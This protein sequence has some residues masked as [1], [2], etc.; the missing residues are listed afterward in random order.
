MSPSKLS[1]FQPN[2]D[3][4]LSDTDALDAQQR[5]L[6]MQ[7]VTYSLERT[8]TF[9][10][11]WAASGYL[12]LTVTEDVSPSG[13]PSFLQTRRA[14]RPLITAG[15]YWERHGILHE[16]LR[17][18]NLLHL[19]IGLGPDAD[20]PL[21]LAWLVPAP[22]RGIL[23]VGAAFQEPVG[24]NV[25]QQ[26]AWLAW[27]APLLNRNTMGKSQRMLLQAPGADQPAYWHYGAYA[28]DVAVP[29]AT[30]SE[31]VRTLLACL[32]RYARD[33]VT[34]G[35]VA[36]PAAAADWPF[37]FNIHVDS[38]LQ[39]MARVNGHRELLNISQQQP[40]HTKLNDDWW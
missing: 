2:A 36:D 9:L 10:T 7:R 13:D 35:L 31:R 20:G 21:A 27:L 29:G 37:L 17:R 40:G 5:F 28:G 3:L 1:L 12:V 22:S 25:G 33:G 4:L 23:Q 30:C 26:A 39:G 19:P 18:S 15:E 14:A 34:P 8:E 16:R 38:T 6:W 24:L 32:P 11:T